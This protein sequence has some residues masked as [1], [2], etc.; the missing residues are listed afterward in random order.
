MLKLPRA[1][2]YIDGVSA[3]VWNRAADEIER[4]ANM[5]VAPPLEL[6]DGPAGRRLSLRTRPDRLYWGVVQCHGP[7][8]TEADYSDNRYWVA[9]GY[10]SNTQTDAAAAPVTVTA[11]PTGDP[12]RQ[13]VTATNFFESNDATHFVRPQTIVRVWAEYD[14]GS[15][16]QLRWT[17]I[18]ADEGTNKSGPC[19]SSSSSSSGSSASSS[20]SSASA[21]ASSSGSSSGSTGA[22]PPGFT[23]VIQ[24]ITQICYNS[25]GNLVYQLA[26]LEFCSGTFVQSFASGLFPVQTCAAG[27]A[28]G[29]PPFLV[30]GA[31]RV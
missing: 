31:M 4:Q 1:H 10:V 21:S 15:P 9:L 7:A 22:C 8:G 13:V 27:G 20:S 28:S 29:L 3:Q 17:M 25:E 2:N 19:S 14:R 6:S 18:V 16:A 12:R 24:V 30:P 11:Y 23:G 26:Y 5:Q